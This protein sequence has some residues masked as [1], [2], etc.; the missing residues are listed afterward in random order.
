[1]WARRVPPA[2]HRHPLAAFLRKTRVPRP[3]QF[4]TKPTTKAKGTS[5]A[6]LLLFGAALATGSVATIACQNVLVWSDMSKAPSAPPEAPRR[7]QV[8]DIGGLGSSE[9]SEPSPAITAED[10]K[11]KLNESAYSCLD[12]NV[13]G[14]ARYD[15]AQLGSN[16]VCE[17]AYIHGKL[18][19]PL[20]RGETENDWMAWGVFDG[21]NGWQTSQVLT[22]QL[23]PYV[24]RALREAEPENG[25]FTDAAVHRAIESAFVRLD[26]ELVK[27]AMEV[28]ESN[29]S[30]P[31]KVKRLEPAYSGACALLTLYDP[32]SRKLHVASTGDCR[33]VLGYKTA[34]GNWVARP[35]TKDQTGSNADEIARLRAQFPDEPN[36]FRS[37]G[38]IYGMQPSRSFGDGVYK[39]N[40]ELRERLRTE[41]NAYREPGDALYPGFNDGP[42][43]TA[44]P[45]VTTIEL[46]TGNAPSFV[47]Q[48]TDGLWDTMG[49][50]NAVDLVSRW[51]E[52]TI[53]GTKPAMSL[54][55]VDAGPVRFGRF[56]CWYS[57]ARATYQ[58][59][60]AAVHLIRNGLG[61]AHEEM[62]CSALSFEPPL[63]RW[64]RDDITVQ[65]MFFS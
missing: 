19:D 5:S 9:R 35:L 26:D 3:A 25:V 6:V 20:T 18:P 60:N 15:G 44:L 34:D 38:R 16:Q 24:R 8:P 59:S 53:N 22:R 7:D 54:P 39:W 12:G 32:S 41:Y 64:I 65:V 46:P 14:V 63:S 62:V 43:L 23:L 52:L 37:R 27:S 61:G 17:D 30:Y 42:Y 47:I 31:E 10:V 49:N 51:S 58:D 2:Y 45:V 21:H 13:Q 55:Q 40:R 50:Q 1:M 56:R 4:S 28:T 33:A 57:E 48:A 29:L 36:I 11:A